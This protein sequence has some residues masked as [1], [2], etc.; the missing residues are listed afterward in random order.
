MFPARSWRTLLANPEALKANGFEVRVVDRPG[1]KQIP[2]V[3]IVRLRIEEFGKSDF[4]VFR[5]RACVPP[6]PF[7]GSPR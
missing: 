3:M 4:D 5:C 6:S 2:G 7:G 1:E